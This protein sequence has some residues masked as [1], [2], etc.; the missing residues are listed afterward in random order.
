[1]TLDDLLQEL[2]QHLDSHGEG[3]FAWE[4]VREWPQGAVDIFQNAGWIKPKAPAKSVVC[5]GCEENCFMPVHVSP[6]VRGKPVR[7]FVACVIRDDMGRIPI[8]L[9]YLQQW[10]VTES[11]VAGWIADSL[12]LKGKPKRDRKSGTI[13]I[14]NVQGKKKMGLLE[15]VSQSPV[16]LKASGDFLPLIEVVYLEGDQ[17]QIDQAA[18]INMVDRPPP[19]DRYEPS[20]AKREANKLDTQA[21]H[22]RWQKAYRELK[23]KNSERSDNWCSIQISRMD[24]AEGRKQETIRKEMKK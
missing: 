12:E 22:I 3:A 24:I 2:I 17:L 10:Q 14:G 21:R 23:R 19:S 18:I 15:W 6:A 16:S 1:M 8:P 5:P 11:Q 4:Q 7:A 20:I 13:H 9:N